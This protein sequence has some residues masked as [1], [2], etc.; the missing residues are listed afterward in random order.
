MINN[1]NHDFTI[2]A[3]EKKKIALK[4]KKKSK[5]DTDNPDE[6]PLLHVDNTADFSIETGNLLQDTGLLIFPG[7][8]MFDLKKDKDHFDMDKISKMSMIIISLRYYEYVCI[9][10]FQFSYIIPILESGLIAKDVFDMVKHCLK[11]K[12][13]TNAPTFDNIYELEIQYSG[14]IKY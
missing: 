7:Y 9:A 3:T 13:L 8:K 1:S 6:N 5:P 2:M 14:Y 12:L 10:K 4:G 11:N